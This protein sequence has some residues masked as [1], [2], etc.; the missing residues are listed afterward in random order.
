[1]NYEDA[2]ASI[3][4][5]GFDWCSLRE[6]FP[7]GDATL[8]EGRYQQL[9]ETSLS[10]LTELDERKQLLDILDLQAIAFL[11]QCWIQGERTATKGPESPFAGDAHFAAAWLQI[12]GNLRRVYKVPSKNLRSIA[13]NLDLKETLSDRLSKSSYRTHSHP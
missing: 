3:T 2:I 6:Y 11:E 5:S 4:E 7:F 1:M 12:N 8:A 10:K 13:L 9:V